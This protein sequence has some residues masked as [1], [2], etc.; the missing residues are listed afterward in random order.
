VTPL[1][2]SAPSGASDERPPPGEQATFA[3]VVA[4]RVSAVRARID[5]HAAGR[6]V[7]IVAVTKGFGPAAVDAAASAGITAIGENY[8]QELITKAGQG[9]GG[10]RVGWHFI[11]AV[12]RNKV[13]ALAPFVAV[14]Q[15]VDR[16]AAADTIARHSPGATALVEVNLTGDPARS[17]CSWG[18]VDAVV[19]VGRRAGLTVIGLMGI[20]P[21]G[22]PQPALFARLATTGG[23]LGLAELSMGMTG[24]Y[25]VAVAEG[26]TM[27]RLGT[28]LFGPRPRRSDLRR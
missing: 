9:A 10:E 24:D 1:P 4:E 13:A 23:R 27:V 22:P 26:S 3:D 20:G 18:D 12:Q 14:W 8:A 11:G 19:D 2:P 16:P 28:A 17:G 15:T 6:A 25:E 7:L 5:A 21:P